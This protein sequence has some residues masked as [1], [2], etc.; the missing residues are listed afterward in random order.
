MNKEK[1]IKVLRDASSAHG[2][3]ETG[4]LNGVYDENWSAWYAAFVVGAVGMETIR[5]A[6][7]T[8]L[9]A[10]AHRAHQEQGPDADWPTFYADYIINNLT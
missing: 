7:L 4:I 2:D 1:L 6:E 3:Y 10:D 5:P 8:K 9:L